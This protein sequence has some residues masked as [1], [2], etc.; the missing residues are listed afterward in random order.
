ATCACTTTKASSG[1]RW[2]ACGSPS[3]WCPKA[4]TGCSPASSCSASSTSSSP[5]R[6]AGSTAR[7]TAASASCSTT[8]W[9]ACSPGWACRGWSGWWA[10]RPGA[11]RPSSSYKSG[12]LCGSCRRGFSRDS[13]LTQP[14]PQPQPTH[15]LQQSGIGRHSLPHLQPQRLAGFT[16]QN[17]GAVMVFHTLDAVVLQQRLVGV[18]QQAG[19]LA[20]LAGRGRRDLGIA[21]GQPIG[22]S[23]E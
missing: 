13:F 1:T 18:L 15:Q 2:S 21:L 14:S 23:P 7:Y 12:V 8:C 3:G 22:P 9:P 5:G 20:A 6:S 17:H 16:V 19:V 10:E 4:G 11:S